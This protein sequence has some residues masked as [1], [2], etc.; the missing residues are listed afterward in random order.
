MIRTGFTG[1]FEHNLDDK[2][3]VS[4]PSQYK[5]YIE[6]IVIT[7][8]NADK[9]IITKGKHDNLEIFPA[10]VWEKMVEG[11]GQTTSLT[12]GNDPDQI[13]DRSRYTAP[14][15]LDKIGRI[16]L[17]A[18]LKAVAKIKKKVVFVGV[19]DRIEIWSADELEKF[20]NKRRQSHG[21]EDGV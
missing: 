1:Q 15:T 12:S 2:Q 9:L 10:E 5:K 11:F 13:R 16:T 7:P 19:V 14:V 3:R 18:N 6:Q 8:E 17:N 4:L 21:P 20:D